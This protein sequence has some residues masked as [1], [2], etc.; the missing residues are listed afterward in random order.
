MLQP[1]AH[2][3][4][5]EA[6]GNI[7]GAIDLLERALSASEQKSGEEDA[8]LC[9][10]IAR[11]CLVIDEVRAFTNWCHEAIRLNPRDGEPYLMMG[12]EL[13]AAGRWREAI[14][15]LQAAVF[16]GSLRSVLLEEADALIAA[17]RSRL[18]HSTARCATL[19][20]IHASST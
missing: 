13:C 19:P 8:A 10:E 15:T 7:G 11:M 3:R 20:S 17:A 14:E 6:D 2:A 5:L 18:A 16:P 12:R 4:S 1:L 9:K